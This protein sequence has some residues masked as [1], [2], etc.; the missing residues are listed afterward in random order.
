[1]KIIS[2]APGKILWLG[3]YSILERLNPGF[4]TTVDAFS[5]VKITYSGDYG[6]ILDVPQLNLH[7]A[8]RIEKHTGALEI[9]VEERLVLL[10]TAVETATR[11][12]LESGASLHGIRIE[13]EN[14]R[15]FA[16]ATTKDRISKS[17]L[18]GSAAVTV[19]AVAG[20]LKTFGMPPET[21]LVH[22]LSQI[23]HSVATGK[24][25]SGFDIAAAS[26][27][28]IV[29]RRYSP[30]ILNGFSLEEG[31]DR[32]VR[33]VESAWDYAMEKFSMP[34]RFRLSFANF[35][36]ESM[37]TTSAIGSVSDFKA[38]DP[39]R[40]STLMGSINAQNVK[41][42]EALEA[43]DGDE[44][45]VT[46]FREAFV[47]GRR[48]TKELGVLSNTS[49]EPDDCTDLIEQSERNG[50]FVA[51]L[52]G[53]GGRDAIAALC[54]ADADAQRLSDFWGGRSDLA[55]NPVGFY[56]KGFSV[57]EESVR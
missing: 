52:P 37:A 41:A 4:V 22:K 23:A 9:A 57:S 5:R 32:L 42:I 18:G 38:K 44:D 48:L 55:E 11:Y 24:V 3:G 36:G 10:K 2:K 31:N 33:L 13:T 29:Y 28:S 47:S 50:A 1:M 39:E 27:G 20:V 40:Y 30:S 6:V 19:A 16:Y 49:I 53:A 14:D 56:N 25:G 51:K 35:V 12:A 54:S 45:A 46:R 26:Y 21:D 7:A 34:E 8:G 15:Q 17:G 43:I